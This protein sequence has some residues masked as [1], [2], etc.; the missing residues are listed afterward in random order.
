MHRDPCLPE[1]VPTHIR[2]FSTPRGS[3]WLPSHTKNQA[4]L[5]A[6]PPGHIPRWAVPF[7]SPQPRSRGCV[8]APADGALI[9]STAGDSSAGN[10]TPLQKLD[11]VRGPS[12]KISKCLL[13][14]PLPSSPS[15]S[16]R[17][18][19]YSSHQRVDEINKGHQRCQ[20]HRI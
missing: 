11:P 17:Q 9:W 6:P 14:P 16:S 3:C 19:A 10:S 7:H 8:P 2:C 1:S 15:P 12:L 13:H 4:A 20:G 18:G 5:A